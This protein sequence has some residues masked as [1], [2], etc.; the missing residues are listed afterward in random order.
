M[1]L[2]GPLG[3]IALSIASTLTLVAL[4]VGVPALLVALHGRPDHPGTFAGLGDVLA[5]GRVDPVAVVDLIAA[6]AWGAWLVIAV[7]IVLEVVAWIRG[8]PTPRLGIAGPF[9]PIVRNLVA[10]A[11]LLVGTLAS[12]V[13]GGAATIVTAAAVAP[14]QRPVPVAEPPPVAQTPAPTPVPSCTVVL[15]D[16]LWGLAETHLKNPLRWREIFELNRGALQPDGRR[17][18]DPNLIIPGWTLHL[19]SDADLAA[20]HPPPTAPAITLPSPPADTPAPPPHRASR[21]RRLPSTAAN[22]SSPRHPTMHPNIMPAALGHVS[23]TGRQ[24]SR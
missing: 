6:M 18:E 3:R 4:L 17:L 15:H 1:R 5:G 12:P 7:A 11:T 21:N 8:R 13:R 9:Q 19:P 22:T 10:T 16:T 14:A 20:A 23:R 24:A 2:T